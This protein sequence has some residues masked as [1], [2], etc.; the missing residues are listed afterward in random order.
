MRL[1]DDER[2]VA[3]QVGAAILL[4]FVVLT[5][6]LY[7][8]TIVPQ[9]NAQVEFNH[10][11]QVR[12]DLGD[13]RNAIVSV[14]GGTVG[15]SV[16][17]KLGTSYPERTIFV[18]PPPPVGQLRTGDDGAL[19]LENAVADGE[20]GDFWAGGRH[21]VTT[22][23]LVYRPN[24]NVYDN[25]PVTVYENTVL[26]DRYRTANRTATDQRLVRGRTITVVTLR[27][28]YSENGQGTASV[29]LSAFSTSTRTVAVTDGSGPLRVTVPT[30]M[31]N[32]TWAA[33]LRDQYVSN[34]GHVVDQ[35]YTVVAGGYNR[36]VLTLERDVT[37]ELRMAGVAVGTGVPDPG[38]AYAVDA[39]GDGARVGVGETHTLVAEVRDRFNNP[40]SGVVVNASVVSGP[41]SVTAR[42]TTG[43]DGRAAF[44]YT[45]SSEG[46]ATVEVTYSTSPGA[47]ETVRYTVTATSAGAG[48]YA[49]NWT[50]TSS[51]GVTCDAAL[52]ECTLD[53]SRSSTIDLTVDTLPTADGAS[54]EYAVN[55]TSVAT[56]SPKT[57]ST[58]GVGEN[59]TTLTARS[60]GWVRVYT[61]S[62]ASGD[63]I[64]VQITNY[65]AP[66]SYVAGSASVSDEG[67]DPTRASVSFAVENVDGSPVTITGVAVETTAPATRIEETVN[68][69]TGMVN[70]QYAHEVY[71]ESSSDDGGL[72]N[73]GIPL[74]TQA[75][76][77][78]SVT[79]NAGDTATVSLSKFR[80]GAGNEVDMTGRD[81]TVT[82]YLS[83]GRAVTIDFST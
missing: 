68:P 32:E 21:A 56:V 45:A 26:V 23:P 66:L 41:G 48:A 28:N 14:P 50:A 79:V 13:V 9:Q 25:A 73:S 8:A 55:D 83:D 47:N 77:S 44:T 57:G 74:G 33:L 78:D 10:N 39:S 17:V 51:T 54:V 7:Q 15:E 80:D 18:N 64:D 2:G 76:L 60:N 29:D 20:A 5:I 70:A 12:S 59:T 19:A 31:P 63:A 40:V 4:A 71:A 52:T 49:V 62:G 75:T 1:R 61:S 35:S 37:Y 16:S 27:G 6:A 3:I 38:P 81:L 42:D 36:L 24:Y 11:Q 30:T 82:L 69:E 43:A 67:G 22:R 53:A 72:D 46:T 58:D 65:A 34:G